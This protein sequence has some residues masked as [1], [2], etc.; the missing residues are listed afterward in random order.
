LVQR[1]E[2]K[3]TVIAS[4]EDK[5]RHARESLEQYRAVQKTQREQEQ[6]EHAHQVQHFR[7]QLREQAQTPAVKQHE[8]TLLNPDNARLVTELSDLQRVPRDLKAS[9]TQTTVAR[10]AM[11]AEKNKLER[12]L[13]GKDETHADL[14]AAH[15][16]LQQQVEDAR[17]AVVKWETRGLK[18]RTELEVQRGLFETL[19]QQIRPLGDPPPAR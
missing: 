8:L 18:L 1:L 11:T 7:A 6:R 10:D 12:Q 15:N 9:A 4:L 3:E 13:A 14:V 2:D 5:H 16:A 19:R 17:Q